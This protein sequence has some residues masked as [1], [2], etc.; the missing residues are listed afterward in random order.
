[1]T[2]HFGTPLKGVAL[3]AGDCSSRGEVVIT[4]TGIEGGGL[5]PLSPALRTGADLVIDLCPDLSEE[6]L[7]ARLNRPRGKESLANH[8]RKKVK[9]G[10]L[11]RALLMEFARPLPDDAAP[12]IKAL[13][14]TVDGLRPL[15]E[16]ISVAG[17]LRFDALDDT[18]ML[19]DRPGVFAAG[20]MLDWEAPTGG[21]LITASL[22]TGRWAGLS[23]SEW[24]G[25]GTRRPTGQA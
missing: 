21:Y 15:D 13:P 4:A 1:M 3:R 18:L 25:A 6:T 12:V 14:V 17:G 22:A 9:L 19:C 8:L 10:P 7:R 24:I 5:Y 20:E 23:A 16:A 2:P 11:A